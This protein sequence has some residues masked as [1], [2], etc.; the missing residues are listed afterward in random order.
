M[1][2]AF[3]SVPLLKARDKMGLSMVGEQRGRWVDLRGRSTSFRVGSSLGFLVMHSAG[4]MWVWMRTGI[5]KRS[6]PL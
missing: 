5:G 4:S 6:L 1:L 2:S 3:V